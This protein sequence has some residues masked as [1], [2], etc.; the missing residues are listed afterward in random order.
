[1]RRFS[2][3][4]PRS[5]PRSPANPRTSQPAPATRMIASA[6]SI[7]V[8]ALSQRAVP[9]P[10]VAE[11]VLSFIT[12]RTSAAARR[13]AGAKPTRTPLTSS[14]ASEKSSTRVSK[15]TTSRRGSFEA[16]SASSAWTPK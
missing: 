15:V 3:A 12:D 5:A 1:M 7:T 2:G 11:R 8:I 10:P 13:S 9:R 16:P 14:A 6:I 4:K